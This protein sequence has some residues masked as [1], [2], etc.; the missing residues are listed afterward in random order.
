MEKQSL[1]TNEIS[2]TLTDVSDSANLL[3]KNVEESAVGVNEITKNIS[4][5]SEASKGSA[6]GAN[7][8]SKESKRL[9]Q[10]TEKLNELVKQFQS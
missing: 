5:I 9:V 6:E 3:A 10:T 1:T 4:G 2:N 7:V 8:T